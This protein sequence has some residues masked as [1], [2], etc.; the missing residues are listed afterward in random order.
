MLDF[1]VCHFLRS[2]RCH[3]NNNTNAIIKK[4]RERTWCYIYTG[5]ISVCRPAY[6]N[7]RGAKQLEFNSSWVADNACSLSEPPLFLPFVIVLF[8]VLFFSLNILLF[9]VNNCLLLKRRAVL[10]AAPCFSLSGFSREASQLSRTNGS[11]LLAR[12][13]NGW[14]FFNQF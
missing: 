10:S 4:G 7:P 5:G 14:H 8:I 13:M 6:P 12:L 2:N 9:R 11:Q 1:F 3:N